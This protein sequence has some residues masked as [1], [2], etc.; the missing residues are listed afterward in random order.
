MEGNFTISVLSN[1]KNDIAPLWP[2]RWMMK[3]AAEA[4]ADAMLE[5]FNKFGGKEAAQKAK[6]LGS[7][8]NRTY[9][10]L[11]GGEDEAEAG[12]DDD[13]DKDSNPDYSKLD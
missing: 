9:K 8:L 7:I 4:A 6:W 3:G 5:N 11:I 12:D 1:Y 13:S 10:K 2:P